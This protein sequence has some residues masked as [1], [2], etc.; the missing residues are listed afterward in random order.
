MVINIFQPLTTY[1]RIILL[2]T[3]TLAVQAQ[4]GD[5]TSDSKD[6]YVIGNSH[7]GVVVP[8]RDA[9][10]GEQ[11]RSQP[12]VPAREARLSEQDR[13][14]SRTTGA[15]VRTS[16]L[17][18]RESGVPC[19]LC[20][21]E[22][23]TAAPTKTAGKPGVFVTREARLG[24][25]DR[26]LSAPAAIRIREAYLGEQDRSLSRPATRDISTGPLLIRESGVPCFLCTTD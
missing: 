12:A 6:R 21:T 1:L 22:A 3:L 7:H 24:E 20:T 11:D 10:L 8:I 25:Q 26:S 9:Y 15:D 14:V 13:S 19:Y 17:V 18:I 4:T 16:P 5:Q 2:A 23:D